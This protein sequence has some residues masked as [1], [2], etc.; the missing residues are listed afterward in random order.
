MNR[1]FKFLVVLG[2]IIVIAVVFRVRGTQATAP[3]DYHGMLYRS[4][5]DRSVVGFLVGHQCASVSDFHLCPQAGMALQTDSQKQIR[6][7][8]LYGQGN[9]LFA[10]FAGELPYGITFKDTMADVQYKLG[11]PKIPQQPQLGWEPGLP[12][13]GGT[14]DRIHYWA[15]Y[16]Q[17]DLVIV[18][19][20]PL[21]DN[22][23][24]RIYMILIIVDPIVPPYGHII[25][26]RDGDMVS[27]FSS[28]T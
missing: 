20:T 10:P 2:V 17:Y 22:L 19:N 8:F 21:A 14:P 7:I 16:E 18:Y 25:L 27:P 12:T 3:A 13:S 6:H 28:E 4:L 23:N 24:A 11:Q 5:Y 1:L 26:C 9:E 15:T